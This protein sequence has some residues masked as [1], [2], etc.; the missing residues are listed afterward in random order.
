MLKTQPN[1]LMLKPPLLPAVCL[2]TSPTTCSPHFFR[3]SS[4]GSSSSD[5]LLSSLVPCPHAALLSAHLSPGHLP[6]PCQPAVPLHL[7]C[8]SQTQ[9]PSPRPPSSSSHTTGRGRPPTQSHPPSPEHTFLVIPATCAQ[10]IR[11]LFTNTSLKLLHF[12][13]MAKIYH[14]PSAQVISPLFCHYM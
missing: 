3:S 11:L 7:T 6:T 4:P 10:F 13:Q 5:S 8:L 9:C 12:P 2:P 1:V 14:N